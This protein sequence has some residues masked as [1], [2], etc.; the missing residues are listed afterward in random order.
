MLHGAGQ[1][2][3]EFDGYSQYL[4]PSTRPMFYTRYEDLPKLNASGAG[5]K[6]FD[7]FRRTLDNLGDASRTILLHIALALKDGSSGPR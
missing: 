6:F 5:A 1:S 4:P 2:D 3:D 7:D